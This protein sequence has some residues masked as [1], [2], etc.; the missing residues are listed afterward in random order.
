[1]LIDKTNPDVFKKQYL[2]TKEYSRGA[3]YM[4]FANMTRIMQDITEA[5][6][7][8]IGMDHDMLRE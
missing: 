3:D 5:H 4:S 7:T 6:M 1:M 2:L 8:A